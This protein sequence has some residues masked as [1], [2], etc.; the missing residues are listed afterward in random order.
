MIA[1]GMFLIILAFVGGCVITYFLM[2]EPRRK[3]QRQLTRL[4]DDQRSLDEEWERYKHAARKLADRDSTTAARIVELDQRSNGLAF[5]VSAFEAR[6]I[7]YDNLAAE[8]HILKTDLRNIALHQA[9]QEFLHSES[10]RG[11]AVAQTQRDRLGRAY[12]DE[13]CS[14]ARKTITPSNYFNIKKRVQLVASEL[15]EAGIDLT[16]VQLEMALADLHRQYELAVRAA[17]EREEQARLRDEMRENQRAERERQEAEKEFERAEEERRRLEEALQRARLEAAEQ[18]Q[19]AMGQAAEMH[20]EE[21]ERLKAQL[22][23]AEAKSKRA[24]ANAQ[25]TRQGHVYVISNMGSFGR[26]VFKIGMTRRTEYQDR[27]DELGDASVPFPFDVHMAIKCED[28]PKLENA[29]HRVFH[30]RRVNRVNL[31]KEFFRVTLDEIVQAVRENHGEV[32]YTADAEAMEF[33]KSQNMTEEEF[34]VAA[35]AYA[36]A[37]RFT[38]A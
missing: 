17:V 36:K 37:E 32:E 3:A 6:V 20:Q 4:N 28:A 14:T 30:F 12:F 18:N 2:D 1:L 35:G 13:V 11:I 5:Q 34:T 10:H 16:A 33:M 8:N 9:H 7:S 29:L 15:R 23:E 27:I 21:V 38:G 25:I 31:R 26:G 22:A 24:L 19:H